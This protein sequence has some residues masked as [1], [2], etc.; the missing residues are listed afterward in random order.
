MHAMGKFTS[1][2]VL[3][4]ASISPAIPES[5]VTYMKSDDFGAYL[6]SKSYLYLVVEIKILHIVSH[7]TDSSESG[8]FQT[9]KAFNRGVTNQVRCVHYDLVLASPV[10]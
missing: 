4:T 6:F 8:N 3:T 5:F 1:L 9:F 10:L 2:S 7:W